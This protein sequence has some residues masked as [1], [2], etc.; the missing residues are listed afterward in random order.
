M[1][2]LRVVNGHVTPM[3]RRFVNKKIAMYLRQQVTDL[4]QYSDFH[5]I[6]RIVIR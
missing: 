3:L 4:I 1:A 5:Y 2:L 6:L